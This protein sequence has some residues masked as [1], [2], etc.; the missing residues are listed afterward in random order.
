MC[1]HQ[2][3]K[4][5]GVNGRRVTNGN[6]LEFD[7]HN[8]DDVAYLAD[9]EVGQA[10]ANPGSTE[11]GHGKPFKPQKHNKWCLRECERCKVIAPGELIEIPDFSQ[12][13]YNQPWKHPNANNNMISTDER[14]E[15]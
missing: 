6:L 9:N 13:I 2:C 4:A 12:R 7:E 1:D 11:G 8:E 14:F 5:W 3:E 15:P 10:P